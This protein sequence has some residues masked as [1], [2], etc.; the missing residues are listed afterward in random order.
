MQVREEFLGYTPLEEMDA[1]LSIAD[2]ILQKCSDFALD[3]DKLI[4]Q[5]YDGCS[6]VAAQQEN[7]V[8]SRIRQQYPKAAFVHCS[9]RRLNLV[10][11]DLN[12]LPEIR[13][14]VG[15]IKCIIKFF[16]ESPSRR[17]LIPSTCTTVV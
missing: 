16:R 8:K 2:R 9:W 7:R 11:N 3:L 10:I 13:N 12:K 1:N 5:G 14:T 17:A 15:I 4:G 6:T